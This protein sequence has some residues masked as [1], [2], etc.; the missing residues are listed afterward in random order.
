MGS[1]SGHKALFGLLAL[2]IVGLIF[3]KVIPSFVGG[4]IAGTAASYFTNASGCYIDMPTGTA[5][6]IVDCTVKAMGDI[7]QLIMGILPYVLLLVVFL[8]V[9]MKELKKI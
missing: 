6:Q 3:V 4:A 8:V 2:F 9:L 7:T 1:E 5:D